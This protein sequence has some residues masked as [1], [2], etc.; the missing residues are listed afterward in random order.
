MRRNTSAEHRAKSTKKKEEED[1]GKWSESN[2]KFKKSHGN[3]LKDGMP[4]KDTVSSVQ[5][6]RTSKSKQMALEWI[7]IEGKI[8]YFVYLQQYCGPY[9]A[10]RKGP[11]ELNLV[12]DLCSNTQL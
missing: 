8:Q 7:R 2:C 10:P 3:P 1:D 6:G 9:T 5:L 4:K 12:G 11:E